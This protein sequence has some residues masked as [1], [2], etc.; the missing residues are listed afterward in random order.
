MR[1]EWEG[2]TATSGKDR[3]EPAPGEP[4]GKKTHNRSQPTNRR[5]RALESRLSHPCI[6]E[7]GKPMATNADRQLLSRVVL[8]LA[9]L[10][11]HPRRG[12]AGDGA[13]ARAADLGVDRVRGPLADRLRYR[14]GCDIGCATPPCLSARPCHCRRP[15][16][17]T[18]RR[19]R[20]DL[21]PTRAFRS[22]LRARPGRRRRSPCRACAC[23]PPAL[24]D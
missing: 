10:A 5:Q 2:G 22:D 24:P 14:G 16:A 6:R 13:S 3:D 18:S 21:W 9:S 7:V 20:C 17:P 4:A 12:G 19:S 1:W 11:R 8:V 15:S 23:L